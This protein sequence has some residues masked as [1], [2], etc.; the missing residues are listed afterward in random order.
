VAIS[1]ALAIALAGCGGGGE[2]ASS[3]TKESDSPS[4]ASAHAGPPSGLPA[5]CGPKE[6]AGLFTGLA[7]AVAQ[8]RRDDAIALLSRGKGFVVMTI[9]HGPQAGQGRVDSRTPAA[10]YASLADT[11]GAVEKPALLGSVV[12]AVAPLRNTRKGPSRAD[13]AAGAEFAIRLGRH[14]LAGKVGI[15]CAAG[16]IY[17]GAMTVRQLHSG[18]RMCGE[19]LRMTADRPVVCAYPESGTRAGGA[20]NARPATGSG[21]C[22]SVKARRAFTS[23]LA[24]FDHGDYAALDSLFASQLAFAWFSSNAPGT[25]LGKEAERRATL[26]PYFRRRHSEHDRLRLA[27]LTVVSGARHSTGLGFELRRSSAD[28]RDG[29]WLAESGKAS[30]TCHGGKPK[31]RA[32][33][34]GAARDGT[35]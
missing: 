7:N 15:D 22:G 23:F 35:G 20:A 34:L 9:Y 33:S 1:A 4:S 18:E 12:G 6:V 27:H 25:R 3:G 17:L 13:P 21:A 19:T 30:L 5:G 32:V 31:F 24:A 28:F 29:Q 2:R 8:R 26:V 14:V 11:F 16:T 10:A